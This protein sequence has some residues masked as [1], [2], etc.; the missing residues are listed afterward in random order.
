MFHY[1]LQGGT[2]T[3][4]PLTPV[5][6]ELYQATLPP[7]LCTDSPEWYFSVVNLDC[8]VL[9]LPENAPTTGTFTA[10]VAAVPATIYC[11]AKSGLDLPDSRHRHARR[12]ERLVL[13]AASSSWPARRGRTARA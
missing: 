8:G 10:T 5:G 2:F 13:R 4:Q 6:G 1:R 12:P 9:T 7:A 3:T 11:T